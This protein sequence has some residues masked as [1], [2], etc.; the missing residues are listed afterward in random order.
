MTIQYGPLT[1]NDASFRAI[2]VLLAGHPVYANFP[3]WRVTEI[4]RAVQL[5][6]TF[7]AVN[8]GNLAGVVLWREISEETAKRAIAN[9]AFPRSQDLLDRAPAI[10]AIGFMA[11]STS[12]AN[13]LTDAFVRAHIGRTIVYE[14]H[15]ANAAAPAVFKWIDKSG[16]RMG[17]NI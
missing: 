10:A 9:R 7:G 13:S 8:E 3:L 6:Q 1:N 4:L 16:R 15:R 11:E 12:L 5:D 2:C 14:R 17:G